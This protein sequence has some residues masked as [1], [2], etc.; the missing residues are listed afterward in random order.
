MT[1][2]TTASRKRRS[3]SR[4]TEAKSPNEYE[5]VTHDLH[6]HYKPG[7][8]PWEMS[9]RWFWNE[10]YTKYRNESP[11]ACSDW[12]RF[13][14]PDKLVYRSYIARQEQGELYLDG[15]VEEFEGRNAFAGMASRWIDVLAST[16]TPFRY[17]GHALMMAATYVMHMAPSSY[18]SN[19]A[20]F[21]AGDELRRVQRIAYQTRLLQIARHDDTIGDDRVKWEEAEQWQPLRRCLEQLLVVRDWGE[22]FT[23]LNFVV[24]PMVDA[25]FNLALAEAAERNGDLMTALM[26]RHLQSDSARSVAWSTALVKVATRDVPENSEVL[27]RWIGQAAPSVFEAVIDAI[28]PLAKDPDSPSDLP[29]LRRVIAAAC[30]TVVQNAGIAAPGQLEE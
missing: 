28:A 29:N 8:P 24:K 7:E 5:A 27:A 19:V 2:P 17:A 11:F 1:S 20:A 22:A 9:P 13:R 3:W 10:W 6:W 12:N 16:Y 18:I 25:A 15:I 26:H 23:R 30:T 4:F 14:D 21:Q